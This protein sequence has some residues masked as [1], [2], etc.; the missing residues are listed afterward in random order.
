MAHRNRDE[1]QPQ[2]NTPQIQMQQVM[3]HTGPLPDPATLEQYDKVQ[4]GSAERIIKAFELE[5]EHRHKIDS[6]HLE[7]EKQYADTDSRNSFIGI[8]SAFLLGAGAICAGAYI[9]TINNAPGYGTL[10]GSSGIAAI[11]GAFIYGTKVNS[12]TK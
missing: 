10:F 11:V 6:V 5:I 1:I 2:Q 12:K 7:I 4:P 8:I 3:L 9:A